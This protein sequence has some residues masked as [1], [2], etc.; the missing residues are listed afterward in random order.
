M[1]YHLAP[2]LSYCCADGQ[3][4]FLDTKRDR[5]FCLD[6]AVDLSFQIWADGR[7]PNPAD[8]QNLAS[9]VRR[10]VLLEH[11]G[12]HAMSHGCPKVDAAYASLFDRA[13][14]SS[15]SSAICAFARFRWAGLRLRIFGLAAS[16]HALDRHKSH[17]FPCAGAA[18][19]AQMVASAFREA[20]R[21]ATTR[22]HCLP[23]ALAVAHALA[24]RNV[25]GTLV[26]GVRAR[27]FGAH[28]WVQLGNMVVN[29][30]VDNVRDF[31]PIRLV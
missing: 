31:T 18:E 23:H 28:A 14:G 11:S 2:N 20:A 3:R 19:R 16:L 12:P 5:Y 10:G 25:S 21:F 26:I 15:A 9:L 30:S 7:V 6:A 17:V 29:D 13:A 1:G 24:A 22:H 8:A 27:P 4:V